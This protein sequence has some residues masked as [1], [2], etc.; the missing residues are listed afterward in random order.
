MIANRLF[1]VTVCSFLSIIACKNSSYPHKLL[2][3]DSLTA[4]QPDSAIVILE[5]MK[6]DMT[7]A[8]SETQMYYHL[9]CIKARDK[10]YQPHKSS[11]LIDE[12]LKY[13]VAKD[14]KQHLPEAYY[15]AG[16]VYRDLG[17][18]PQALDY[19]GKAL[20]ALSDDMDQPLKSKIYSQMGTLFLYQDIYDEALKIFKKAY[21]YN[22][23]RKDSVAMVYSLRDIADAYRG[24]NKLDSAL[25]Y[26]QKSADLA[27]ELNDSCLIRTTQSQLASLFVQ[28]KKYEQAKTALQLSMRTK[29]RFTQSAVYSIASKLYHHTGCI[30]SAIY[31]YKQ[32][33]DCG[34][35]YAKKNASWGLSEISMDR[36]DTHDAYLYLKQYML[37]EDSVSKITNAEAIRKMN[38]LYNYQ[39]RENESKQLKADNDKKSLT[40]IA[41]LIISVF[42]VV[43]AI[44]Y[45]LCSRVKSLR[46]AM[47]LKEMERL[48]IEQYRKSL[49]FINENNSKME[50]LEHKLRDANNI[51][52]ALRK[53][54]EQQQEE[55]ICANKQAKMAMIEIANK[56]GEFCKSE[57]GILL[58]NRATSKEYKLSKNEWIALEKKINEIYDNFTIKLNAIY[59]MNES[60]QKVCLLLKANL[61]PSEIAGF[62]KL[63]KSS[64]SQTR[65]RLYKKFFNECGSGE[66]WDEFIHSL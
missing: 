5:K 64:I 25:C 2:Q 51:N 43:A 21:Q 53:Q 39:L 11:N 30:D 63:T 28:L 1:I 24:N 4:T 14:D 55:I 10:A 18:A 15:Y 16:R 56:R 50:E 13:Y 59:R 61:S 58:H 44:I 31:Y 48:K 49:R 47:Q 40:I 12:V 34:T 41:I 66:M 29:N 52:E 60:E 46:L 22:I 54:L 42:I 36:G 33:L 26:Y 8:P 9:L 23:L 20:T 37:H 19:F 62:I 27:Y 32:L 3:A 35:I 38:S 7:S 45:I 57:I 6:E 65:F 17:D